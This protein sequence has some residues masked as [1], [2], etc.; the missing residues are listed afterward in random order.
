M[1]DAGGGLPATLRRRPRGTSRWL[2]VVLA[3][4]AL[5]GVIVAARSLGVDDDS[6]A[7]VALMVA[8]LGALAVLAW[9]VD[10]AWTISAGVL[11]S[12]MTGNWNLVGIPG[13][14]APDRLLLVAGV[15]TVVLRSRGCRGRAPLPGGGLYWLLTIAIA[16]VAIS[17]AAAGTL[18]HKGPFFEL[19]ER[20][21][22]LQFM[23]F[24]VAPVVFDDRRKRE[25]LLAAL[26][27]L[28]AY[29]GVTALFET[30]GLDALVLPSFINNPD[31]GIHFGRARGPF[32]EAVTNGTALYLCGASAVVGCVV[33]GHR[34]L[35]A[36]AA[37]IALLDAAGLL[38]TEERSVWLGSVIATVIALLVTRRTRAYLIPAVAS[39]L[40]LTLASF[41]FIP[42]LQEKATNRFNNDSTVHDRQNLARAAENMVLA[43]PLIG[44]GWNTF[45]QK[46][47]DYFQQSRDYPLTG[48][49][50]IIHNSVLTYAAELGLIGLTLWLACVFWAVGKA[51]TVRG[52]PDTRPWWTLLLAFAVFYG[53]LAN[54]V[55]P[56][57][58]PNLMLW[59]LA[60]V[61]LSGRIAR[62]RQ[63]AQIW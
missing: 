30:V 20:F 17:A 27:L 36:T 29:L 37:A 19:F 44:F 59:L 57:V 51:L 58:F 6:V 61:V 10:P 4:L 41:A 28:G 49:G 18:L 26:V 56:Q 39:G 8:V 43:R 35:R 48:T 50:T 15:G 53:V 1:I 25:V 13:A 3:L 46:S 62:D 21:G 31:V 14:V 33:W 9:H 2:A 47:Q 16:Y 38:F 32:L 54:F 40:V 24:L 11:L 63:R 7:L 23:L 42:G 45:R 60:G 22:I 55:Y 52:P 5:F 12:P 34:W